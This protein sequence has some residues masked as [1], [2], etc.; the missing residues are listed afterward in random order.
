[1]SQQ[2]A[3]GQLEGGTKGQA[4]WPPVVTEMADV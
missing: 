2:A 3:L 4:Q 1:M